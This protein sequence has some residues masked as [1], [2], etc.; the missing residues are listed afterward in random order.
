MENEITILLDKLYGWIPAASGFGYW[1]E[2]NGPSNVFKCDPL[3]NI[4]ETMFLMEH[5]RKQLWWHWHITTMD[6][7]RVCGWKVTLSISRPMQSSHIPISAEHK[8]DLNR[9][10]LRT[11]SQLI[12]NHSDILDMCLETRKE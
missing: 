8:W 1:T 5:I 7:G 11:L 2:N 3:Q 4:E 10:I 9:A 6:N 12:S